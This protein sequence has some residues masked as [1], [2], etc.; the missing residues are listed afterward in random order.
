MIG[1]IFKFMKSSWHKLKWNPIPNQWYKFD[2][3]IKRRW[4]YS[5]FFILNRALAQL[6]R[7]LR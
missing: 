6:V 3:Y 2:F 4:I 1:M 7:A 5:L